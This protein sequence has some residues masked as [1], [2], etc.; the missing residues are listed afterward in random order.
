MQL[1]GCADFFKSFYLESSI[2]LDAILRWIQ[3]RNS[4][5]FCANP[6]KSVIDT[7]EM[8]RQAFREEI[9]SRARMF[10]WHARFRAS[11]TSTEDNQP[12]GRPISSTMPDTVAKLHQLI[13]ED[14]R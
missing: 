14:Q 4:I 11:R 5:K 6:R 1:G 12:T 9:I 10:E 3:K 8:I 13:L 7:L 2:W